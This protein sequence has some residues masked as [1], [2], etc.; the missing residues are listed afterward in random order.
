MM[1]SP[2]D[3]E[4]IW[5]RTSAPCLHDYSPEY[6]WS[7]TTGAPACQLGW[8]QRRQGVIG[9]MSVLGLATMIG[10]YEMMRN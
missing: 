6:R 2:S 1:R 3:G 7:K 8:P 10:L 9:A 4:S 5:L